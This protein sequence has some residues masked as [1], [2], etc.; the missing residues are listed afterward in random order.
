M[1]AHQWHKGRVVMIKEEAPNNHRFII[2]MTDL[3]RF[4]FYPGQFVTL[5][6]P[7][8]ER[9][10]ERWRSYSIA[11]PP[12]GTNKFELVIVKAEGGK[13]TEYIWDNWGIGSEVLVRGPQGKFVLP[14]VIDKDLYL[15]CTGTGIA[16]FRS[17]VQHI[18]NKQ[19]P[20]KHIYLLFGCRTKADLLYY[21][22]M[23][24]LEYE[25]EHFS[26]LPTLSREQWEGNT[27]YVH[28]IYKKLLKNKPPAYFY[29]CGWKNM[30]N[31][32]RHNLQELGYD[33][34]DIHFE[35]YG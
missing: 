34:K 23:R 17:M 14:E 3:E 28:D 9:N 25:D 13:G 33:K 11:S 24:D 2:E 8:G 1:S 15:I 12:D 16:P 32:T 22:E 30:I 10:S 18:L 6:L 7:I 5:D 19:I 29:L 27:G 26:Y 21:S 20:H 35:L 4:D 31:D